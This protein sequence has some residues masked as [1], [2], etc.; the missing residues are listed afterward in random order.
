MIDFY[1]PEFEALNPIPINKDD[2]RP[3]ILFFGDSFTA[4]TDSY[5]GKLKKSFNARV[6]NSAVSGTGVMEASFMAASRISEF[7]PDILVYQIYLG[8][9]LMDI[10][11]RTTGDISFL[12][13]LYHSVSDRIRVVKFINYRLAQTRL[14][15]HNELHSPMAQDEVPF[16]VE[17]YNARQKL[18]FQAEPKHLENVLELKN[19]R[20]A[21]LRILVDQLLEV[22]SGLSSDTKVALLLIPHCAQVNQTYSGRMALLGSESKET[23]NDLVYSTLAKELPDVDI[24]DVRNVFQVQDSTDHRMY[25]ENDPHLNDRGHTVL[26]NFMKDYLGSKI[27]VSSSE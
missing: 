23:T 20:D 6:I 17:H 19:G 4:N 15:F 9:D 26:A 16:S 5:V 21:D 24:L 13:R 10:R 1:A 2:E 8:N 27:D 7:K 14:Q 22:K 25:Y 12:R 3:S 18:L 11:H